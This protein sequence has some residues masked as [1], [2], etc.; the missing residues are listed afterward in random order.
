MATPEELVSGIASRAEL[1]EFIRELAIDL[2]DKPDGWEND[3]LESYLEALAAWTQDM[4]GYLANAG[5]DPT[6]E[7]SWRIFG[8]MLIAARV[9]E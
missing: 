2:R 3:S 8:E 6:A 7:A 9:Y 4:E 5:R 1:V